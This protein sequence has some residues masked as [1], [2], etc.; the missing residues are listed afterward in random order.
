MA[1]RDRCHHLVARA[2]RH[3]N[4]VYTRLLQQGLLR[5]ASRGK[6]A[7][8]PEN[9]SQGQRMVDVMERK[10][11]I[12]IIAELFGVHAEDLKMNLVGDSLDI[13][14]GQLRKNVTLPRPAKTIIMK[15]F[16]NGILELKVD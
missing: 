8:M 1:D 11:G 13:T 12:T 2:G 4:H 6:R 9:E 15:S 10:D 5:A 3:T 14:A 16:K 7:I